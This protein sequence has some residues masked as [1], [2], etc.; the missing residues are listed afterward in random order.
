MFTTYT[1]AL[2]WIHGTLKFGIKPGIKRMEWMM[3][4]LDHPERKIKAVHVTGTNGKGS[5]VCYLRNILQESGRTVG[6]FT[7]PY[8]ESFNERISV[9]GIA[10]TDKEIVELANII[11][12]LTK[13]LAETDLGSPTEFEIITAMAFCYFGNIAPQDMIIFEVGLGGRLDSTNIIQPV[14]SLITNIGFD[15]MHILGNTLAEI[16]FE[17]AGII[18]NNIPVIT[19]VEHEEALSVINKIALGKNAQMYIIDNQFS[20]VEHE[21]CENGEKFTLLTPFQKLV[22]LQITMLGTHQTKNASL[23]VMAATYLDLF[24]E[25]PISEEHI[26][27]G[28]RK[29][30]WIGRFEMVSEHPRI[31][32][33][34]AHNREGIKAL[35][36]TVKTHLQEPVHIIF[37]ALQDKPV[38]EMIQS[39]TEIAT[40]ITFTSFD[41]AR[42]TPAEKLAEQT[43]FRSVFIEE[44]WRIAIEKAKLRQGVILITGS[45]YFISEIRQ[46]FS[47]K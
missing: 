35:V 45:L 21:A 39:L 16:A 32:I 11:L 33:D 17:K 19:T 4:K 25:T 3:E 2:N 46:I 42:V 34:G 22:D 30:K 20:I 24:L 1:E 40:T 38:A 14:L 10:I 5:T 36:Q 9:N 29:A 6:T 47:E 28:L 37:S 13:Q 7:S 43:S 15:H 44:D 12:P 26:R 27:N 8:I 31:I 23:A 18:K 41:F